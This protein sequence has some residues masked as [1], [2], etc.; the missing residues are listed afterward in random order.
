MQKLFEERQMGWIFE[1]CLII[2]THFAAISW[3]DSAD[4]ISFCEDWAV[5]ELIVG[6]SSGSDWREFGVFGPKSCIYCWNNVGKSIIISNHPTRLLSK[7]RIR[8]GELCSIC[9]KG[10]IKHLPVLFESNDECY[11][12]EKKPE[13]FSGKFALLHWVY[14]LVAKKKGVLRL[15]VFFV[16]LSKIKNLNHCG[17]CAWW[18]NSWEVVSKELEWIWC[19]GCHWVLQ[20]SI[21]LN[22]SRRH[23]RNWRWGWLSNNNRGQRWRDLWWDRREN[24]SC[25]WSSIIGVACV[26]WRVCNCDGNMASM[27]ILQC[28]CSVSRCWRWWMSRSRRLRWE[29]CW[30][31]DL[32]WHRQVDAWGE[33]KRCNLLCDSHWRASSCC[34][35]CCCC[36]ECHDCV[37]VN[38]VNR[39]NS[40]VIVVVPVSWS[41]WSWSVLVL[42]SAG[43]RGP[44]AAPAGRQKTRGSVVV[45][46]GV[47]VIGIAR[48]TLLI[49]DIEMKWNENE[50]K[51]KMKMKWN[52]MKWNEMK[53]IK[54]MKDKIK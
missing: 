11:V 26:V 4:W 51:M 39:F 19:R 34:C 43:R 15:C 8:W 23:W 44:L 7:K 27:C 29:W 21:H 46:R 12:R 28:Q 36:G 9:Q 49:F 45:I 3:R 31:A 18:K 20:F 16:F 52:E 10:F 13:S 24:S 14:S 25:I 37:R 33:C 47:T 41:W 48:C 17:T 50:M 6:E 22:N 54:K 30:S 1:L 42:H 38:G 5:M 32:V 53:K 35:C 2:I 40:F